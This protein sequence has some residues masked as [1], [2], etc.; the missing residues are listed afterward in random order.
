MSIRLRVGFLL[1]WFPILLMAQNNNAVRKINDLLISFKANR[2][3][4]FFPE[5]YL[6]IK[7]SA[8][9]L[10]ADPAL[11]GDKHAS[12][13]LPTLI[14]DLM[15]KIQDARTAQQTFAFVLDVRDDALNVGATTFAPDILIRADKKLQKAAEILVRKN[16]KSALAVGEEARRLYLEAESETIRKSLLGQVGIL[17][18]ESE[19]LGA[20]DYAP[21]TY[22]LATQL[23]AQLEQMIDQ[24]DFNNPELGLKAKQA[25]STAKKLLW[26]IQTI[27]RSHRDKK[28]WEQFLLSLEEKLGKIGEQL[29]SRV[30]FSDG[31]EGVLEDYLTLSET[32]KEEEQQLRKRVVELEHRQNELEKKL[33]QFQDA[34]ENK[35]MLRTKIES[36]KKR[37]A[38]E[39]FSIEEEN[40][41]LK[42]TVPRISFRGGR[43]EFVPSFLK[44]MDKIAL[45]VSYFPGKKIYINL[46]QTGPGN[47]EYNNNLAQKR[48]AA[49]KLYLQSKYFIR[50][51]MITA[52]GNYVNAQENESGTS[53]RV[54]IKIDLSGG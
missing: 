17:I 3:D 51:E 1:L 36:I 34:A 12:I 45:A 54:E 25:S 13:D 28:Q 2:G 49:V 24:K 44:I 41:S 4:V 52:T 32:R 47:A 43:S 22:R 50:D 10:N 16:S 53:I 27:D 42:I 37:F 14:N 5:I 35:K 39:P 31:I 19:D 9:K 6:R 21:Q 38:S 33:A 46:L 23:Q 8:R 7:N 15:Q 48:A 40:N 29:G 20:R 11:S 30:D 26:I 18:Q